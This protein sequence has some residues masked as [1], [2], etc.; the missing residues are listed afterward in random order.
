M[1][2]NK[3]YELMNLFYFNE[4]LIWG[5]LIPVIVAFILFVLF[6]VLWAMFALVDVIFWLQ[7]SILFT[8]I[9][10]FT[11]WTLATIMSWFF[12][13]MFIIWLVVFK[14][15]EL[16]CNNLL[17][18]LYSQEMR[19][20]KSKKYKENIE[21]IIQHLEWIYQTIKTISYFRSAVWLLGGNESYNNIYKR[22]GKKNQILL[23]F[24]NN[25]RSDLS[26]RLT[27]HQQSLES[28]KLEVESNIQWTT[29]LKQ[30]SE[31]QRTRLDKQIEQFEELQRVLVKV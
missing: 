9:E 17:K 29:E 8:Q 23:K 7:T 20:E 16:Y 5:F 30:A 1:K 12:Y 21:E 22:L 4:K 18:K 24:I 27:E 10:S 31:L 6:L 2:K 11:V 3:K 28:A 15:M 26:I 19:F 13:W 25:L 14:L